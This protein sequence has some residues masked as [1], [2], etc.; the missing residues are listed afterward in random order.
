MNTVTPAD[1]MLLRMV[2]SSR[3]SGCGKRGE[4][5]RGVESCLRDMEANGHTCRA[6]SVP[7]FV[8]PCT[9]PCLCT[10]RTLYSAVPLCAARITVL[11][12]EPV[13]K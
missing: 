11:F 8:M 7:W 12:E 2:Q 6:P 4:T 3:A 1:V 9:L 13:I 5:A 10:Y